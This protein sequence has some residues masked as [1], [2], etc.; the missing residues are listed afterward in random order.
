MSMLSRFATTGGG[1]DPYWN[2]VG[3]LLTGD[4]L[5]DSSNNHFTVSGTAT[6]ASSPVK[7]GTGSMNFLSSKYLSTPSNTATYPGSG[8][9]TLEA[10]VYPTSYHPSY[11]YIFTNGNTGSIVFYVLNQSSL[12]I[13]TYNGSDL[14]SSSTIP[15]LNT[16]SFVTAQRSG[17][18]LQ[19]YVNGALTATG[20]NSTNFS[21]GAVI[22]GGDSTSPV[23]PW[24]GYM[25]DLRFT[26]GVARYTGSYTPPPFPPTSAMPIG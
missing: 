26:K 25:D 7:Y 12:I 16:W 20:T 9:F 4:S 13:R 1:G 22:I 14:L 8:D 18:T 21:A 19:I 17:S 10:W 2:N 11:S 5:T 24:N 23:A 3:L 15:A 6:I